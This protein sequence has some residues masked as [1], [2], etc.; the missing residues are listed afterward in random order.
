MSLLTEIA[1]QAPLV[2]RQLRRSPRRTALTFLGL[3]IAFFLFTSLESLLYT[4]SNIVSGSSRD[5]LLFTRASD[6]DYWRSQLPASYAAAIQELPGVLAASPVR[7]LFGTGRKEGSFA[8]AMGIEPDAHLKLGIP[9]GVTASELR[10]LF[11]ERD[12]ALVGERLL[13]DNDWKVGDRVTIGGR[14]RELDIMFVLRG[15]VVR[16]GRIVRVAAGRVDYLEEVLGG[17]GSVTFIQVRARDA[18]MAPAVAEAIDRRFAN[19]TTPTET[20]TEKAHVAPF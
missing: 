17:S 20:V 18:G 4:M 13:A 7:V 6:P 8:V 9:D 1:R 11:T 15:D 16:G 2:A 14:G 3:V 12:A 5:A 19:Y 10:A